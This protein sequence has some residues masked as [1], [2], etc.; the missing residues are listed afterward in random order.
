MPSQ[1]FGIGQPEQPDGVAR[2]VDP[3][4]AG[5]APTDA[6]RDADEQR[7]R[8]ARARQLERDGQPV[9]DDVGDG[10][11]GAGGGAEVAVQ[12]VPEVPPVL[13]ARVV[14]AVLLADRG[15]RLGVALL[16]RRGRAPGRRAA[17][18]PRED[19]DADEEQDER[20][21]PRPG[22]AGTTPCGLRPGRPT[23]QSRI[24]DAAARRRRL[25][26]RDVLAGRQ[27]V[28]LPVEVD[29]R[30][31]VRQPSGRPRRRAPC[32]AP[33]PSTSR[34]LARSAVDLRVR[35][36]VG[37]HRAA[38][39]QEVGDVAVRVEPAGPA[40]GRR[41]TRRRRSRRA[42]WRT[43]S[44]ATDTSKPASLAWP[45]RPGRGAG[46]P[47][48]WRPSARPAPGSSRPLLEELLRPVDVA[49]GALERLGAVR[50]GR[51]QR[52]A[53]GLV[54]ALEDDLVDEVAVEGQLERLAELGRRPSGVSTSRAAC[55]R[56]LCCRC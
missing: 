19:D 5:A 14:Q 42:W 53:G 38:G 4:P 12:R 34:R 45:G 49:P 11:A 32:A 22:A 35:D 44:G 51:R 23:R 39:V 24:L 52:A 27:V 30:A 46:S 28:L 33:G 7:R 47:G 41:R 26:A 17:P 40:A 6:R 31:V 1:K 3:R 21:A 43:R 2:V 56:R 36:A 8:A 54:L 9:D 55:R 25:D 16:T 18:G 48:S 37:V 15:E 50:A 29:E 20:R 13:D 10:E